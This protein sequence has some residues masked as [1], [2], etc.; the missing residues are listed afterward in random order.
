MSLEKE[1]VVSSV[2]DLMAL[3]SRILAR[4][5]SEDS[6]FFLL[7]GDSLKAIVLLEAL[8][9]S[10]FASLALADV[11]RNPTPRL[12]W[13]F[14]RGGCGEV[15]VGVD[16]C[17][18]GNSVVKDSPSSF[19]N[20][21]VKNSPLNT[22]HTWHEL[23][24]IPFRRC[25]DCNCVPVDTHSFCCCCHGGL[26][27]R[28]TIHA[29]AVTE[30]FCLS[31]DLRVEKSLAVYANKTLVVGGYDGQVLFVDLRTQRVQRHKVAGEIRGRMGVAGR[32]G[33][34]CT[35][36]G[37]VY[38]F[39]VE[40]QRLLGSLFI[41]ANCH[42]APLV[43]EGEDGA[44]RAVCCS[45]NSAVLLVEWW[46]QRLRVARRWSVGE[47][48]FAEPVGVGKEV[49]V[50][51]V[52]GRVLRLSL[53]DYE[54][55]EWA[56]EVRGLVYAKPVRVGAREWVFTTTEGEVVRADVESG[57]VKERVACG[58]SLLMSPVRVSEDE[59]IVCAASGEVY[60]VTKGQA[61]RV[62]VCSG[63][64]F[65][66]PVVVEGCVVFGCRND[67]VVVLCGW[68]VCWEID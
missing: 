22:S 34:V 54:V 8:H 10:G 4:T 43:V 53:V 49:L 35:Y 19:M 57:S 37:R 59:M 18:F 46:Q 55:R 58:G 11:Y 62:Y 16:S 27:K 13:R 12:L 52:K 3:F 9:Q 15:C 60:S 61:R 24:S 47:P 14:I 26:L 29:D 28:V 17:P 2:E 39:D 38:F 50:V 65:S 5:A 51:T 20:S 30:D 48:V 1:A 44:V 32:T 42:A 33:V 66:D 7:G 56:L 21:P 64:V 31:L 68:D 23:T 25:V 36:S 45:I 41:G 63:A 6:D 40:A 67:R